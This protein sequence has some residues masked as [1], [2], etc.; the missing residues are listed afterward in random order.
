MR[1]ITK[2]STKA[3]FNNTNYSKSNTFV[4]NNKFYLN[5][6][7][8]NEIKNNKLITISRNLAKSNT[9][10]DKIITILEQLAKHELNTGHLYKNIAYL[11]AIKNLKEFN[12]DITTVKPTTITGVGAKISAKITEIIQTGTLKQ[13]TE[14]EDDIYNVMGIGN[15]LAKIL[16]KKYKITK[17]SQIKKLYESKKIKLTKEQILGIKYYKH[18][19]LKIQREEVDKY[20]QI[21]EKLLPS[22]VDM[23]ITGSYRRE[24]NEMG[25]IDILLTMKEHLTKI[26]DG[27]LQNILNNLKSIIVAHI[28]IGETKYSGLISLSKKDIVRRLDIRLVPYESYYSALLYFTGSKLFNQTIRGIAKKKG[29]LLNEYGLYK[30]TKTHK[31]KLNIT[32]EEDIFKKL[33]IKY[34]LPNKR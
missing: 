21:L 27:I 7:L 30:L 23:I 11:R 3:F 1:Q 5:N 13:L 4:N 17:I 20:K 33:K 2:E 6:K 12:G 22:N 31:I 9:I 34:V 15:K 28:G 8:I 29:F 26:P 16:S 32:S 24:K 18:L 19:Q 10:K 14:I 25:D